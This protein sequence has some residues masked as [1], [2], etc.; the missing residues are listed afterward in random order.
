M[1][2]EAKE[3]VGKARSLGGVGLDLGGQVEAGMNQ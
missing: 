3:G 2:L 1:S